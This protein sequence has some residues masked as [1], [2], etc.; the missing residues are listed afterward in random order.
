MFFFLISFLLLNRFWRDLRY[1][2]KKRTSI[3]SKIYCLTYLKSHVVWRH[4]ICNTVKI[5]SRYITAFIGVIAFEMLVLTTACAGECKDMCNMNRHKCRLGE[6]FMTNI[7]SFIVL[8]QHLLK[9]VNI[10]SFIYVV[11]II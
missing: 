10:P 7:V 5:T 4:C 11:Y 1:K 9:S 2:K 3:E 6:I 8:R